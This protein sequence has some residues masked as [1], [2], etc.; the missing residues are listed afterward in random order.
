MRSR[1]EILAECTTRTP[2]GDLEISPR[3]DSRW[4][5]AQVEV[6]LD[7]RDLLVTYADAFRGPS[8]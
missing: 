3:S 1:E 6:L 4:R 8:R 7:I 5:A 2:E